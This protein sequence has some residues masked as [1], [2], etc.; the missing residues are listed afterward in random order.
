M[1]CCYIVDKL[2][3][4]GSIVPL[5]LWSLF[6]N[7]LHLSSTALRDYGANE[8]LQFL[9]YHYR[10]LKYH[11]NPRIHE[12]DSDGF[13]CYGKHFETSY[14][15]VPAEISVGS[16]LLYRACCELGKFSE[17]TMDSSQET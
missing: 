16:I 6:V 5:G 14:K 17:F 1:L 11:L 8:Y 3:T 7:G 2:S 13:V 12:D 10:W 4:V 15:P 9:K